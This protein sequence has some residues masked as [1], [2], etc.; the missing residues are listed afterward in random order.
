[1]ASQEDYN[2]LAEE[3]IKDWEDQG[4]KLMYTNLSYWR[5]SGGAW[6]MVSPEQKDSLDKSIWKRATGMKINY[7]KERA[8]IWRTLDAM[9]SPDQAVIFDKQP[10]LVAPNGTYFVKK[11][12]LKKHSPSHYATRR[13]SVSVDPSAKCPLWL[14]M[15]DRMFEDYNDED[16]REIVT[17]MQQWFGVAVVASQEVRETRD[18]RRGLI[19]YGLARTGKTTIADVLRELLGSSRVVAPSIDSLRGEFGRSVLLGASALIADDGIGLGSKADTTILK[20]LITGERMTVNRKYMLPVE[21]SFNGPVLFT[22]NT[23]PK[24][25]DDTDATFDRLVVLNMTRQFTKDDKRHLL[26]HSSGIRMLTA[27]KQMSGVLN[28]A[29]EGYD[30]AVENGGL[31]I[32]SVCASAKHEF[33]AQND[34]VY[35][36]GKKMLETKKTGQVPSEVLAILASEYAKVHHGVT[37]SRMAA[38]KRLQRNMSDLV[39]GASY[40]RVSYGDKTW[41]RSFVG[42]D[43]S[44]EGIAFH[45]F[46]LEQGVPGLKEHGNRVGWKMGGNVKTGRH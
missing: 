39:P 33:R 44:E 41:V 32:P 34:P 4:H 22:T 24:I 11:D 31:D 10:M 9:L 43:L 7:A 27:K 15:L 36:F 8:Q 1:M 21:Y 20:P 45:K 25:D 2:E 30:M 19:L 16:R 29:L 18:L 42:L 37:I 28:W 12:T 38:S 14:D 26:G 13:I 35:D 5:Y 46:C 3:L 17:F 40:A 6:D 23:L